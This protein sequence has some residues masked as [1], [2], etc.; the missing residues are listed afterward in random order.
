MTDGV[1]VTGA[2]SG[3]GL[4]IA[5]HLAQRG[6][7]VYASVPEWEQR[8]AVDAA[9]A[10]RGVRLRVLRLDVTDRPSIESAVNA[11]LAE[12]SGLYGVVHSAGLGLRGF[13]EDLAETE[14]RRLFDVNVFGVMAVTR[15]VLPHMRTS[16]R[17]RI[18]IITSAGGRIAS[19]TLSG[20]CAGKFALE[21]FG[22]S[23]ALEVAPLGV[24]VSLVE[25]GIVMT[26]HFTVRRGR[27]R[28]ATD[29]GSFYYPWFVQH[30]K[31]VDDILR[32][33]RLTPLDVAEAAHRAL[34]DRRP[35]LRYVVGSRAKLLIALR[36]YLPGELFDR[37]YSRQL[38][39]MVTRPARPAG[40]LS[41]LASDDVRSSEPDRRAD[42]A[43]QNG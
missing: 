9:A 26:P 2:G 20:Y 31:I 22:E 42:G 38:V 6:F 40:G 4:A 5:L 36:R 29:P 13:F 39:R 28:A 33:G 1:L 27:A 25:P 41:G 32:A 30:E 15:A 10:E 23:L 11:V 37:L 34:A 12:G 19:M 8:E 16:R 3:F 18:V 17:G 35:K 43:H 14:I 21:G 7:Q 24:H